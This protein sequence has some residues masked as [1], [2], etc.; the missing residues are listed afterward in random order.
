MS[1]LEILL[2]VVL[3]MILL[4]W[5]VVLVAAWLLVRK[6][7]AT[8]RGLLDAFRGLTELSNQ[9]RDIGK[10]VSELKRDRENKVE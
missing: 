5:I 10:S 8:M 2:I 1:T 4:T 7:K 9:I 6:I 3:S